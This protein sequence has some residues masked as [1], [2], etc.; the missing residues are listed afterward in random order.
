[1]TAS[2]I[3]VGCNIDYQTADTNQNSDRT[4]YKDIQFK[5]PLLPL[6]VKLG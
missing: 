5:A 4:I 6:W 1:M 2:S 3:S